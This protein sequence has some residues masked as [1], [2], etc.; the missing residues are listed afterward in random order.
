[1][2]FHEPGCAPYVAKYILE[3]YYNEISTFEIKVPVYQDG[4]FIILIEICTMISMIT[5]CK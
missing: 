1:M 5:H 2:S 3:D 4:F